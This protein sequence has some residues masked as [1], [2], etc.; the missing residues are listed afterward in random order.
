MLRTLTVHFLL[1][2]TF[3]LIF[4]P[5]PAQ[6][7]GKEGGKKEK[8]YPSLLW[9][10]SGNGLDKPSYLF[11]TMHVSNKLVFH[12]N[13]SFYQAIR[14]VE[15]VALE[16][17]PKR[18]QN[19]QADLNERKWNCNSFSSNQANKYINRET[20]NIADYLDELKLALRTE[21]DAINSL[22]YR[23]SKAKEDFEE[24]TFLDLYIYQTGMK[25]GKHTTGVE[26]F[27]EADK[28][29]LE[30]YI[31]MTKEKKKK[32]E[33]S[34]EFLR[35]YT[36][37]IQDAYRKGDLDELISLDLQ[38]E[39]SEAYREVF[40]NQRNLKQAKS[41][42]SI[43]KSSS[44]FVGVGAAHLP[45][46]K[47]VIEILRSMGFTLRPVMMNNQNA[48]F[49]DRTDQAKVP[50]HFSLQQSGDGMYSV[51]VPGD[52]LDLRQNS[53]FEKL[54]R[55]QYADMANGAYYMVTRIQTYAPFLGQRTVDVLNKTDSFLYENIPG[56]IISRERIRNGVYE[57]IDVRSRTRRG[58]LQRSAI[59]FTPAE[60]IIFKMSGKGEY[61]SG[62]EAE[63]FFNSISLA[64][65]A[66]YPG[67]FF[68]SPKSGFA[69]K[70]P[71]AP[72]IYHKTS[73]RPD[74]WEYS[75]MDST[76]GDAW[77][78]L[79]ADVFNDGFVDPDSFTIWLAEKSLEYKLDFET[80]TAKAQTTLN[81]HP[82]ILYNYRT[83]DGDYLSAGIYVKGSAVFLA[84][85]KSNDS[86]RAARAVEEF[87]LNP[88]EYQN[89]EHYIDT[90][91]NFE[92]NMYQPPKL[93]LDLR[94]VFEKLRESAPD[95]ETEYWKNSR[96]ASLQD[97]ETGE[98][99]LV[100][101]RELPAYYY[102][103]ENQKSWTTEIDEL[104]SRS[105]GFI[106]GTP[107]Y[108]F[109]DS[110]ESI[111]FRI[112]DTG[113]Y[114][115]IYKKIILAK[116][117]YYSL[118][119]MGDTMRGLS[120]YSAAIFNSFKPYG[121]PGR[122][123]HKNMIGKYF[124][125][126]FSSDTLVAFKARKIVS[127]VKYYQEDVPKI[128]QAINRLST[129][130]NE[131]YSLKAKLVVELGYIKDSGNSVVP[132][133]MEIYRAT[134]DTSLFQNEVV[135][136]LGRQVTAAS[137]K[138][139]KD[140]LINEPPVFTSNFQYGNLFRMIDDSL[141]LAAGFIPDIL[142]LTAVT[143]Y[144]QPIFNLI[145]KLADSGYIKKKK[146]KRLVNGMLADAMVAYRKIKV[147]AEEKN[148]KEREK[149]DDDVTESITYSYSDNVTNNF[150]Q[151]ISLLV[152]FYSTEIKVQMFFDKLLATEDN[153]LRL[154]AIRQ[155]LKAKLTVPPA[156]I[157][158]IAEDPIYRF[159]LYDLLSA[160]KKTS[161]FPG[162][163]MDEVALGRS[164][165]FYWGNFDKLDS[166]EYL[167]KR[168]V[169]LKD[170]TGWLL[171]YKYRFRSVAQWRI[172]ALGLQSGDTSTMRIKRDQSWISRETLET[173]MPLD[174]QL[175]EFISKMIAR[176]WP[177]GRIFYQSNY[178]Y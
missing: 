24:D 95:N 132:A 60:I 81:G 69:W 89:P 152:P 48:T 101:S 76:N 167:G 118:S 66:S 59:F 19:E 173:N 136:A 17:D 13:D 14:N 104:K 169:Q 133:L 166:I 174:A 103:P 137:Y 98:T 41:I 34:P 73:S 135:N 79:Y 16:L 29:S 80:R 145:E 176:S 49:G 57:G 119:A 168:R 36:D 146:Y 27:F 25:L 125:D 45:G 26:D 138:A 62:E 65:P 93:D 149:R 158:D 55:K 33:L 140:L 126:F 123:L 31:A 155:M 35:T 171:L 92:V 134:E 51:L 52:L 175:D 54:D 177:G 83:K 141:A 46:P 105:E 157:H 53:F 72:H 154:T 112:A 3:S 39:Q 114:R 106:Y 113:S 164:A 139:L 87:R 86:M 9:E 121:P 129:V 40:I 50:V 108:T 162:S 159:R 30:A 99:V 156:V 90:T 58:D 23:S 6:T 153:E 37:K 110:A 127:N 97:K 12:L 77:L 42:D 2:L 151:M 128:V 117:H 148:L 63:T 1:L 44:L 20:F 142:A 75:S 21:P 4:S 100:Q 116:D 43:L 18:W 71:S 144:K 165:I 94:D 143:D 47:G 56:K 78:V 160:N 64:S 7:A 22:L 38:A 147:K 120:P 84:L 85:A 131:Y 15:T 8:K 88:P 115:L 96:Y 122:D 11:G 107:E 61:I 74:R 170:E 150:S 124:E 161:D 163:Y 178:Y 172:A 102:L 109:A 82:A 32:K 28:A 91:L 10:I 67:E 68:T 111:S 5:S 70:F 130:D